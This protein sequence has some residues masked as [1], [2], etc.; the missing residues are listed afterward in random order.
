MP[1]KKVPEQDAQERPGTGALC[2]EAQADGVPCFERG[3]DCEVCDHARSERGK[4]VGDFVR[5]VGER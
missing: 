1:A 5:K 2:P 3:R 4:A